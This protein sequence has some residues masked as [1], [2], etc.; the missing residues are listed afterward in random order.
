MALVTTSDVTHQ[1][2]TYSIPLILDRAEGELQWQIKKTWLAIRILAHLR[3]YC[4]PTQLGLN[5]ACISEGA[6]GVL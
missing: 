2:L 4:T 3:Q 5:N 1:K 6:E